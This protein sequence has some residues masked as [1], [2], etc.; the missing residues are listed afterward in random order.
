MNVLKSYFV[1]GGGSSLDFGLR[2]ESPQIAKKPKPRITKVTIPGSNRDF[3]YRE[4]GFDNVE[5]AYQTWCIEKERDFVLSRVGEISQWLTS[6]D[7]LML[8]DTYDPEHFRLARCCEPLDPEIVMRSAA[9]QDIVFSCDPFRYPWEGQEFLKIAAQEGDLSK[10]R[11]IELYNTGWKSL[12]LITISGSGKILIKV[13]SGSKKMWEG[14]FML[15][16]GMEIDS[17]AMETRLNGAPAN[18]L[19]TAE[20][21]PELERGKVKVE[22]APESGTVVNSA[23]IKPR[24]RTL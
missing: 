5:I 20:G 13:Y 6:D 2:I 1:Y 22:I 21:Y 9:K 8:S 19:K 23:M 7:Y 16:G 24:W 14:E 15:T 10:T 12:P 3:F 18:H 4:E 17:D 11:K